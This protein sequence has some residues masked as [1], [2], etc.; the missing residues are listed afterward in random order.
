MLCTRQKQFKKQRNVAASLSSLV[1][2]LL[3]FDKEQV[4]CTLLTVLLFAPDYCAIRNGI[5]HNF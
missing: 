3:G 1:Q 5:N 4:F 2:R